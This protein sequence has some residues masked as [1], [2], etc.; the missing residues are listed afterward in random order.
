MVTR[1]GAF[2]PINISSGDGV[3]PL[4][5]KIQFGNQLAIF[6]AVL[7]F[8]II[9]KPAAVA[10]EL[11]QALARSK[12]FAMRFEMRGELSDTLGEKGDL[13][14][15]AAR[16]GRTGLEALNRGFFDFLG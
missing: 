11:Q 16:I 15:G 9:Q 5:A 10:D 8:Q 14:G 4:P 13:N 12:I 1:P 2:R 7:V 6:G 3:K